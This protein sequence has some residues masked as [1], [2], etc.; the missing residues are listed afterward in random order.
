MGN[1]DLRHDYIRKFVALLPNPSST[2]SKSWRP[3]RGGSSV[4]ADAELE[5]ARRK[6]LDAHR[7]QQAKKFEAQILEKLKARFLAS[8]YSPFTRSPA[9]PAL[10]L[11]GLSAFRT[12]TK[13]KAP[14][15][16][17]GFAP[18]TDSSEPQQ[19]TPSDS[20]SAPSKPSPASAA[21]AAASS[22]SAA[23]KP[24]AKA[25]SSSES[26]DED[27]LSAY[28]AKKKRTTTSRLF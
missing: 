19:K 8:P 5:V 21:S 10:L 11:V 4:V 18:Q 12:T 17:T 7:E 15:S 16:F 14:A 20:A 27:R 22:S 25:E 1:A 13:R 23:T 24:K 3:A 9:H 2:D 28:R 26:D 6:Q